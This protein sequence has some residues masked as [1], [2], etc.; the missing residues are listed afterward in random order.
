MNGRGMESLFNKKTSMLQSMISK[1]K[2]TYENIWVGIHQGGIHRVGIFR[3]EFT[4][5]EFT[6]GEF[7]RG[8]LSGHENFIRAHCQQ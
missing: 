6:G 7:T 8:E 5:G 4:R 3:G 2:N 1:L